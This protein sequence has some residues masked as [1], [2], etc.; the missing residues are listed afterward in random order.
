MCVY[1]RKRYIYMNIDIEFA[2][3]DVM[4]A[5]HE[6]TAYVSSKM[7]GVDPNA[8]ERIATTAADE[9][10]IVN[11]MIEGCRQLYDVMYRYAPSA[12]VANG[13]ITISLRMPESYNE[14]TSAAVA[15]KL[16]QYLSDYAVSV[17]FQAT[18]KV[19]ADAYRNAALGQLTGIR[20]LLSERE[21]P[22]RVKPTEVRRETSTY[23]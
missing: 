15:D 17:W 10:Y 2:T 22:T 1:S 14:D 7:T 6:K 21:H 9:S 3:S 5:V 4:N 16:R 23:E 11:A 19:E 12:S 8:Y 20:V 13:M 18:N